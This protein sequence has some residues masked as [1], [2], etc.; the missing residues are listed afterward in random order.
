MRNKL[1][2]C[3]RNLEPAD[4]DALVSLLQ[5]IRHE[6][7]NCLTLKDSVDFFKKAMHLNPIPPSYYFQQLGHTFW[8]LNRYDKA[9]EAHKEAIRLSPNSLFA[10][11][12][13]AAAYS[14]MGREEEAKA[15]AA[16]ALRIDPEFSL[17][18]FERT[19]PH[20]SRAR[21]RRYISALG[22]AGLK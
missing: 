18:D 11:L 6:A 17:E 21:V 3:I 19:C 16:E 4:R 14:S 12:G 15:A 8:N 5:V 13:L 1:R 7:G 10:H 20:K 2:Y 22:S 9:I